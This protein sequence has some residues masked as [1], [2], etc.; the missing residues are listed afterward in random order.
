MMAQ[1]PLFSRVI[2][3]GSYLP[4]DRITNQVLAERLA[5]T[6]VE[7]SDEW[8]FPRTGIRARH[9]A[10]SDVS[11]SDLAK[12]AS[13]RAIEAAGIDPQ[14]IDLIIVAASTPACWC[15]RHPS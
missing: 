14:A 13:E 3:S 12:F 15:P 1:T 7:T 9:F 11:T 4:P 8:I 10:A 2:G 5:A 6:G